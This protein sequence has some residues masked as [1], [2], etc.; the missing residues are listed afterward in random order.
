MIIGEAKKVE[1]EVENKENRGIK[2]GMKEG[3]K[4]GKNK[5]KTKLEGRTKEK[6]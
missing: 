4:R 2:N 3:W 1:V 5:R 6:S